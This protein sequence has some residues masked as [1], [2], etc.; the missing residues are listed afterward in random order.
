M[1]L[2]VLYAVCLDCVPAKQEGFD[3]SVNTYLRML[4]GWPFHSS[5]KKRM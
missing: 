2:A 4:M 1:S 3:I 5:E